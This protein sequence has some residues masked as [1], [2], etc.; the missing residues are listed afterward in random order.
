MMVAVVL[1]VLGIGFYHLTRQR[2][3]VRSED[4]GHFMQ[5]GRGRFSGGIIASGYVPYTLAWQL[6]G[7]QVPMGMI[8]PPGTE[9]HAFE[10]TPGA[11]LT[12]KEADVFVYVS[13]TLE[14]WAPELTQAAGSQ[15][16]VVRLAEVVPSTQDP[17]I[18]MNFE[19]VRAMAKQLAATLVQTYPAKEP[20][21]TQ[22]LARLEQ[23]LT[24]L[25]Q[26]YAQ[27]LGAC[28]GHEVVHIGH[29]AFGPLAAQYGLQLTALSGTSHE[30]EHSAKKLA[31]LV[32]QIKEKHIAAIFTEENLSPRLAQTVA[33]ETGA[34]VLPLY[35]VEHIS[36]EDFDHRVTYAQLMRR[37]LASLTRGLQCQAS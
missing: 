1:G 31:R 22:N 18:W 20:V 33:Q 32:K 13:E 14:P 15:T 6:S 3:A 35:T 9:P 4:S 29:L 27:A 17:H 2:V 28:A 19:D 26:A 37:N 25:Q 30:G 12:V 8:L 36:K 21:F 23:E 7:G 5:V 10:P 34:Q 24:D 16:R 11:L